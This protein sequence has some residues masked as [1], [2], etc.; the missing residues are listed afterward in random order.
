MLPIIFSKEQN[1]G[2]FYCFSFFSFP[3]DFT[4]FVKLPLSHKKISENIGLNQLLEEKMT[5]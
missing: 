1:F 4:L 2:I 3:K 5:L